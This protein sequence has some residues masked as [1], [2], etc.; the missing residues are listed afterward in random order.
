M[1]SSQSWN[2]FDMN[3]V[4]LQFVYLYLSPSIVYK[5]T[6]IF[7]LQNLHMYKNLGKCWFDFSYYCTIY[8]IFRAH[9]FLALIP[10]TNWKSITF[11]PQNWNGPLGVIALQLVVSMVSK[12]G[13]WDV[14]IDIG[15]NKDASISNGHKNKYGH[16]G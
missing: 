15:R 10:L 16:V 13:F 6:W 2:V 5:Y 9:Y 11:F 14:K 12:W 8:P 1:Q 3:N 7:I 4:V